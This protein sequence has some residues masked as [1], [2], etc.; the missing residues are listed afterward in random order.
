MTLGNGSRNDLVK[1]RRE[2]VASL[3]LR[4]LTE[5][6]ITEALAKPGK[7]QILNPDSGEPY[8]PQTIHNDLKL[9]RDEWRE[10]AAEDI[11]IHHARQLAEIQEIKRQA[12]LDRDGRLALMAIDREIKLLGTASP[13]IIQVQGVKAYMTVS[14]DDWDDTP[15]EID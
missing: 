4:G 15:D 13:D 2:M 5:R 10:R 6:E 7:Q 9:L 1:K 3:R 14:P 11:K 12:F 8:S